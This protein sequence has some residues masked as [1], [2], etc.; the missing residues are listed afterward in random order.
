M[1]QAV[2]GDINLAD[3]KY[4]YFHDYIER[5]K[6]KD[7]EGNFDFQRMVVLKVSRFML[8]EKHMRSIGEQLQR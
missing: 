6:D 7:S 2:P 5:R 4:N 8:M 1:A 3:P